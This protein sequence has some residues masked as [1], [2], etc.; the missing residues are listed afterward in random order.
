M[1]DSQVVPVNV[2]TLAGHVSAIA[3]AAAEF[4]SAVAGAPASGVDQAL[5]DRV[6][7]IEL[8]LSEAGLSPTA[9]APATAPAA[10]APAPAPVDAPAPAPT[11]AA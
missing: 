7:H 2:H 6:T 1:S 10:P 8:L 4:A 9:P 3:E 5:T 11:P